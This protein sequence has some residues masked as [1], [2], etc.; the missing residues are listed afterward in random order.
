M[1]KNA[2]IS[3]TDK[4]GLIEFAKT[5]REVG[6]TLYSTGGTARKLQ[7]A[8]LEVETISD[9]TGFPEIFSGRVKTLHPKVFGGILARQDDEQ[10]QK[11]A[12]EHGIPFFDLVVVNLYRFAETVADERITIDEAIEQIDIGGVSLIR[13]AAK[14]FRYVTVVTSPEFYPEVA[15]ALR[16]GEG[17][18]SLELR[19]KL[20]A[21]A[22]SA[23][24]TYDALI[25]QYFAR[26]TPEP[27]DEQPQ[28]MIM[29]LERTHSL[30]YGE[31]PHQRAALYRDAAMLPRPALVD[32]EQ[33]QGKALSYNNYM[34]A[35]AAFQIARSFDR[36]AAVI[37]K[38]ANPCG[39]AC[40]DTPAAAYRAAL[41]TDS[42]SAF[43]GIVSFNRPVDAATAQEVVK[44]FTEVVIAPD[45]SEEALEVFAA[46]KNLRVLKTDAFSA[47]VS[48]E[49]EYRCIDGGIL[50][51]D[52]DLQ[53]E[54]DTTFEIVTRR[55]P[56]D[57]EWRGM[58]FAW[59]VV[60]WVK[61]NAVLF[62]RDERTLGIGAGQ[63]SRVD[64]SRIAVEKARIAGLDLQ[65]SVVASDAFFPFAD[66]VITVAEAGAT[67]V[68]QPGGSVRD[69]EV[70]AAANERNMT[71]LFT[72]RRHF[73]H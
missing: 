31:N 45:F 55:K 57:V 3:V 53:A 25:S 10:D 4:S 26:V 34:D 64:A 70:I 2:L 32:A 65:G 54:D 51:Q 66:G 38:H 11:Q 43:G 1:Q 41:E 24:A 12:A 9:L 18:T 50:V 19:Q 69:E 60:R 27:E 17:A 13:A 48:L 63:M 49:P 6:Y 42:T 39:V 8:G 47:P 15:D 5:L 72:H 58:L 37:I 22:F 61:S 44:I 29:V 16:S 23:T 35:D 62:A 52:K 73:R 56:T 67:A 21:A 28:R 14:N 30:R 20:A 7:E 71:M 46:K 59:T 68:I 33:K 40:A 36:P